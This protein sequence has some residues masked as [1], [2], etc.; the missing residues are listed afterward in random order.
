MYVVATFQYSKKIEIVLAELEQ[1]GL[2]RDLVLVLPL[3]KRTEREKLFDSMHSSDGVSFLELP[4]ILGMIG[5]LLG[6]IYGFVL[7]WGPVIWA[8]IGLA[9]GAG[10][11]FVI[12]GKVRKRT[13][14]RRAEGNLAEVVV[15]VRCPPTSSEQVR[16]IL[17][18]GFALGVAQLDRD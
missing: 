7:A 1:L 12:A 2:G 15:M 3:D 9:A 11:G 16:R 14:V 10:L 5:M 8:L 18:D 6:S 4:S 17:W 13:T